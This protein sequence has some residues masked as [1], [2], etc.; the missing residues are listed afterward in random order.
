[1]REKNSLK[2]RINYEVA[3]KITRV[4]ENYNL[5]RSQRITIKSENYNK[6]WREREGERERTRT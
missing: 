4:S 5:E 2:A 3:K 6:K 1:M